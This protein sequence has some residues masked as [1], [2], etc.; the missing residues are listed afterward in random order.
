MILWREKKKRKW[1]VDLISK[2]ID[3]SKVLCKLLVKFLNLL[4]LFC[5]L[6]VSLLTRSCVEWN[7]RQGK[8]VTG[9]IFF[10]I[11]IRKLGKSTAWLATKCTEKHS[12]SLST[13]WFVLTL[14]Y[15]LS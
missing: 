11:E 12:T 13:V 7:R 2:L 3:G 9:T 4:N 8:R 6:V 5:K 1:M 10:L 15:T 14:L